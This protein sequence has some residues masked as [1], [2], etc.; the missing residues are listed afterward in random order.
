[1]LRNLTFTALV[2]QLGFSLYWLYH[3]AS[4][5]IFLPLQSAQE[6]RMFLWLPAK[7]ILGLALSLLFFVNKR[8]RVAL[9]I[10]AVQLIGEMVLLEK[11]FSR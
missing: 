11:M 3:F 2:V 10:S 7:S 4:L 6:L 5:S 8:Y 9:I 1:M